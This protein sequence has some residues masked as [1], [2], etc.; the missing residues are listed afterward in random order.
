SSIDDVLVGDYDE[1]RGRVRLRAAT[2]KTRQGLWVELHPVLA[3]AI[4]AGLPPREDRDRDARLFASS[5]SNALRTSIAR[6]CRAAGIPTWSPH[7]L[8]HR[9]IS[10]LHLRGV[11]WARIGDFVGQRNIALTANVYSHVLIDETEVD[12]A[13]LL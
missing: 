11:P 6:A 13:R 12:Y 1:P 10:P 4:E 2:T 9:R 3:D 7:D 8:R 5:Q